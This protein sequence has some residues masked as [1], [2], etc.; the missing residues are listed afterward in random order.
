[1]CLYNLK[2][3]VLKMKLIEG[4]K[5]TSVN[6]NTR[7]KQA[8][9]EN[10]TT[11]K[12]P[13]KQKRRARLQQCLINLQSEIVINDST[14]ILQLKNQMLNRIRHQLFRRRRAIKS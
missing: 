2:I 5:C 1:M 14:K 4:S 10:I 11:K 8:T 9:K 3:P 6:N 7:N 13:H 12:A